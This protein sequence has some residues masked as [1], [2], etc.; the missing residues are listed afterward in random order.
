LTSEKPRRADPQRPGA[1][2]EEDRLGDAKRRTAVDHV[3]RDVALRLVGELVGVVADLIAH[4][5]EQPRDPLPVCRGVGDC[6]LRERANVRM[7]GVDE[8]GCR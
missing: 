2:G 7:L 5:G 4:R 1:G 3:A 8:C 6:P